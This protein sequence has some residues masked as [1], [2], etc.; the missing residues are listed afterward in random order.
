MPKQRYRPAWKK[1]GAGLGAAVVAAAAGWGSVK[2]V[3][4]PTPTPVC[5]QVNSP[6]ARSSVALAHHDED[7]RIRSRLP[8]LPYSNRHAVTKW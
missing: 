1:L 7:A 3:R 5:I 4:P 8:Q 6:M 2:V